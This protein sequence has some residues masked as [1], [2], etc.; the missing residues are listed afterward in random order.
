MTQTLS[1]RSPA[2]PLAA[3]HFS[4][5]Y[6][7]GHHGN[8]CQPQIPPF[9][10]NSDLVSTKAMKLCYRV[11][12][13]WEWEQMSRQQTFLRQVSDRTI[14]LCQ[15]DYV[16][17]N[18]E[19]PSESTFKL[20]RAKVGQLAKPLSRPVAY[21]RE[22]RLSRQSAGY[23]LINWFYRP[24]ELPAGTLCGGQMIRGHEPYHGVNEVIAS[25]HVDVIPLAAVDWPATVNHW[26]ESNDDDILQARYW[27]QVY[28]WHHSTLSLGPSVNVEAP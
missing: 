1:H 25:S 15:G 19:E 11:E 3:C 14:P 7:H 16:L 2:E 5:S 10:S 22:I 6:D 21:I 9:L 8:G 27:R 24:D 20:D 4:I 13:Q 12:P 26:T 17:V 23:A 28:D 18:T